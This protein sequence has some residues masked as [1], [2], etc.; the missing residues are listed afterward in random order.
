VDAVCW[1]DPPGV[2]RSWREEVEFPELGVAT[3]PPESGGSSLSRI[4][5]AEEYVDSHRPVMFSSLRPKGREGGPAL[6]GGCI[7]E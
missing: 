1:E 7:V 5:L 6:L 3:E 4:V 2:W